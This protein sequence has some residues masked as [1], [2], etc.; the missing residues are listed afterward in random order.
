[1][2]INGLDEG[3]MD[4]VKMLFCYSVPSS[5]VHLDI[6]ALCTLLYDVSCFNEVL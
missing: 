3:W 2:R 6:S 4:Q 5:Q 1:M